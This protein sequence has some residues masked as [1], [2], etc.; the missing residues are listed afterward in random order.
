[1]TEPPPPPGE[2][3]WYCMVGQQKVGPVAFGTLLSMAQTGTV[4]AATMVW[5]D[6]MPAWVPAGGVPELAFAF[7][8][9]PKKEAALGLTQSG[10]ILFIVL[11]VFCI[12]LCWLP[13]V[14]KDLKAQP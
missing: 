11:L 1:M 14:I 7:Q 6:G 9:N 3:M 13:W 5:K 8:T 4:T 10:L 2:A 12:P